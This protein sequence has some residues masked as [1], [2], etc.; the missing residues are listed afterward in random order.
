MQQSDNPSLS[1]SVLERISAVEDTKTATIT[2]TS[3]KILF[4]L[5]LTVGAGYFGWQSMVNAT[6]SALITI[7]GFSIVALVAAIV[8]AF[9]P[10]WA[11]ITGPIYALAQGFVLGAISQ[12]YN[13][14]FNGIVV[15]AIGL[16]G[17]IFFVSLW[18]FWLGLIKVTNKFRIGVVIATLGIGLYYLIAFILGL[19]GVTAPLIF[20]TGTFGI[21]FSVVVVFIATLNLFLD[22]DFIQQAEARKM[23]KIFEWYGAFA[24]MV[25]LI[26]LYIEALRLL[27]KT[28]Q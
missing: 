18:A 4:L 9:K 27:G 13:A 19:F 7:A 12:T 14:Q 5:T 25:T 28:R 26:W 23:P 15:Q 11:I 24:L 8:T 21:V 1:K 2:G 10:T 6:G 16:T 22:F 17:A 3:L 20:D